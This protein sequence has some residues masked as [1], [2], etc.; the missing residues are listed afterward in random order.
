MKKYIIFGIILCFFFCGC[1]KEMPNSVKNPVKQIKI[2]REI[3]GFSV[4]QNDDFFE[5]TDKNGEKF[6]YTR[7]GE[8]F[9]SQQQAENCEKNKTEREKVIAFFQ[10][11]NHIADNINNI[12]V[13]WNDNDPALTYYRIGDKHL[14]TDRFLYRKGKISRIT[15]V[16]SENNIYYLVKLSNNKF[17]CYKYKNRGLKFSRINNAENAICINDG[18]LPDFSFVTDKGDIYRANLNRQMNKKLVFKIDNIKD[19]RVYPMGHDGF[20]IVDDMGYYG[21]DSDCNILFYELFSE[22]ET[23]D[24]VNV[25]SSRNGKFL[26]FEKKI[27]YKRKDKKYEE[28]LITLFDFEQQKEI[29]T[30]GSLF[31][32]VNCMGVSDYGAIYVRDGDTIVKYTS[33]YIPEDVLKFEGKILKTQSTE[34]YIY[35]LT[36]KNLVYVIKI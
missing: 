28:N 24:S 36:D 12:I 20:L 13:G 8:C 34:K 31:K 10:K 32:S 5:I 21:I 18:K 17:C 22:D 11:K 30:K 14:V 16:K 35:V 6:F 4:N 3:K 7:K 27:I 1:K 26:I 25:V 15:P 23:F 2:D 29:W 19:C 9:F 33:D